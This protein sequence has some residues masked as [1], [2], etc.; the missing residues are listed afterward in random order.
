VEALEVNNSSVGFHPKATY[1]L[2]VF[3]DYQDALKPWP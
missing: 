1:T 3:G 2:S